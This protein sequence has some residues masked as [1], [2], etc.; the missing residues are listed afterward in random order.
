MSFSGS[1]SRWIWVHVVVAALAMVATLPGRTHGLGLFTEPILKSTELSRETY[2]LISLVGTLLGGLFCFPAGWLLDRAGTRLG[3]VL[4]AGL[5]GVTVVMMS[6]WSPLTYWPLAV[7]ILLTRGFGQSALSVVSLALIGRSVGSRSGLTMGVY[8][9][10]VSVFFF[11]AFGVLTSVIKQGATAWRDTSMGLGGGVLSTFVGQRPD[12][13]RDPW[14]GIGIG[15]LTCAVIGGIA[16]R[17]RILTAERVAEGQSGGRGVSLNDALRSNVF[18]AFALGTSFYGM[19]G[20]G[21]S[22]FN[23]SILKERGFD[24]NVFANATVVGIPFGLAGNL[25]GGWLATRVPLGRLFALAMVVYA[26][27]LTAFPFIAFEWQ[28]YIYTMV[29]AGSTGLMTV[30]FFSVWRKAFGTSHIARIQGAA[31]FLTVIFS[32]F[33]QWLFPAVK[34]KNAYADLFPILAIVAVGFSIWLWLT[35]GPMPS[36]TNTDGMP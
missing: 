12:G 24:V 22:L 15:V 18:W 25:V 34:A 6:Q 5:L 29:M 2:G 20:A 27:C 33:G 3:Y 11:G 16:I 4:I 23:E 8:S 31:Q 32:G 10:L 35:K 19:V 21:I 9:C 1:S 36:Q 7:F 13:W 14:L 17:P 30:C 26:V 28:V